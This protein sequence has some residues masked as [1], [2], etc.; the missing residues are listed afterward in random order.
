MKTIARICIGILLST[1]I[2]G[3]ITSRSTS[4]AVNDTYL[5]AK[6]RAKLNHQSNQSYTSDTDN[7]DDNYN[8]SE[9][10]FNRQER[11][12]DDYTYTRR[13]RRYY[14]GVWYD[15]WFDPW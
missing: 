14:T 6:E 3:C 2:W 7:R 9:R 13:I 8:D 15:P 5:T 10:I 11:E 1:W 12:Y 4:N